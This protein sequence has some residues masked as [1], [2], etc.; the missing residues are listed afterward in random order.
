M[1][2]KIFK[3]VPRKNRD[4]ARKINCR[5]FDT[6]FPRRHK[7]TFDAVFGETSTQ[8]GVF[9]NSVSALV[10]SVLDGFDVCIFAYV[11]AALSLVER[12]KRAQARQPGS[13]CSVLIGRAF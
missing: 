1:R 3:K 5:S 8:R 2:K 12:L 4:F 6:L 7:Y 10:T 11:I 9:G 13:E